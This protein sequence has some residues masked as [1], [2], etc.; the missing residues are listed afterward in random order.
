MSP[1][2]KIVKQCLQLLREAD[3]S[4]TDRLRI[5][6]MMVQVQ[7]ILLKVD[8]PVGITSEPCSEDAFRRLLDA[9]G[10][11]RSGGGGSGGVKDLMEGLSSIVATLLKKKSPLI[12]DPD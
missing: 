2:Y 6:T 10:G 3:I 11:I 12:T 1:Q 7:L 5:E 4:H 9:M 8:L